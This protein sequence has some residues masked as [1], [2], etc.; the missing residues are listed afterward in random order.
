MIV[1][2][3]GAGMIGSCFLWKLNE[4]GIDDILVVDHLG[5]GEKWQNL[6]HRRFSEY[7]DKHAFLDLLEAGG[8]DQHVECI[9]HMGAC[10]TTTELDADYLMDNNVQYSRRLAEWCL[11]MD[12]KLWY[13]SS[14][15]TYGDGAAGY[16]D[17]DEAT[18]GLRPLNM[19][20]YSKHLFDLWVLRN[21]LQN[22]LTG[23]KFFNVFGPNEYHKGVM[24]SLVTKAF[25]AARDE[26]VVRLFRSHNPEYADGEQ[27]RDFI[28][29]K[30]AV[31]V[32][33]HFFT[34]P[35]T[36]GIFNVGTG[37][38]RSWNALARAMFAALGR[39][40]R[41]EYV[42]MPPELRGKYQYHTQAD[43]AK[44]RRAGFTAEFTSL[45]DGIADYVQQFL[46]APDPYL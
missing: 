27:V 21:G 34:R 37:R 44:L 39:E 24:R 42:D 41:I 12:V 11:D 15:A 23:F 17:E 33:Y 26:G 22:R 38:A 7:M 43:T 16:S 31:D 14:A 32:M 25:P 19:Y 35:E 45:E 4:Q 18:P 5:C 13:A 30:D 2:T 20:G 6:V 28:Y 10:S 9:V 46:S 3:G 8:L 29:V 1:I 36:G 40:G